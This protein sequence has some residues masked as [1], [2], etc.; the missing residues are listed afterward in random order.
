MP[1]NYKIIISLFLA[2]LF[3][4]CTS[5]NSNLNTAKKQNI[6]HKPIKD[7]S[8]E[9]KENILISL[10]LDYELNKDY[11]SSVFVYEKLYKE[12]NKYEYLVKSLYIN[13]YIK[14]YSTIQNLS[15]DNME[16]FPNKKQYLYQN[17]IYSSLKLNHF[18][19]ALIYAK[20]LIKINNKPSNYLF[21]A[22]SYFGLK[23]YENAA[24][25]YKIVYNKTKNTLAML[26]YT[27]I[28]F[29]NLNKKNEA[30]KYLKKHQSNIASKRL[31][32]RYYNI[33][34]QNLKSL[35][36][37]RKI[38]KITK[39]LSLLGNI[40]IQENE[41][42]KKNVS[43]KEI[44]KKFDKSL[45]YRSNPIFENYYGY[46]LL[47]NNHNV[48]KALELIKK[49]YSSNPKNLS[50]KD[51][52]AYA[53]FKNKQYKKAYK[54][55]KEIVDEIGLYNIEIKEHWEIIKKHKDK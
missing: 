36:L 34:N 35:K 49:A 24:K 40:A 46:L 27:N 22:D 16:K 50:F 15:Y 45:Q 17:Y 8:G 43:N 44:Y 23:D 38:Y 12:Y 30:I 21:L 29:N 26:N 5:S 20:K 42:D 1:S 6:I 31:L 41:Y 2:I 33:T 18:S 9:L 3:T 39:N 47:E 25:Y 4:S 11:K 52:L 28:L 48:K 13:V 53:Y 54:L 19:Q 55:M 51:S 14:Q 7:K 37:N 10:A 32:V